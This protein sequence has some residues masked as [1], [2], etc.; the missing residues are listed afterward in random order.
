MQAGEEGCAYDT[1]LIDYET[2]ENGA[3]GAI[4]FS[5]IARFFVP[6]I[7]SA[8][9]I[10]TQAPVRGHQCSIPIPKA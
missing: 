2:E 4:V 1:A 8:T 5:G 6:A 9:R 3:R 10:A 7:L